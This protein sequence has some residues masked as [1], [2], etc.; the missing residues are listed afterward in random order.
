MV[1][2]SGAKMS[3]EGPAQ[4]EPSWRGISAGAA[5]AGVSTL[6]GGTPKKPGRDPQLATLAMALFYSWAS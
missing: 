4:V 1:E 2:H 6:E 5:L 3:A